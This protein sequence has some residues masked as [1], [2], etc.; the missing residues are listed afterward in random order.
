[1]K[2]NKRDSY[3]VIEATIE[4]KTVNKI[5]NIW[6]TVTMLILL[7]PYVLVWGI[8]ELNGGFLL[9]VIAIYI[10]LIVLHE[11]LHLFGYVFI[12]KAK[13]NEVKLGVFWKHLM[14]YAHCKV[15]LKINHYRIAVMMP[16]ILAIG[17]LIYGY[18][19][20]NGLY[21]TIG[22]L[23]SISSFGDF[24]ILWNLINYQKDAYIQDH[25]SEIGCIV[26]V[27]K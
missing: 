11:L 14:P 22:I 21:F 2:I 26:H 24:I 5:V 6:G 25:S 4:A 1:M 12:G 18:A 16:V 8:G 17:P 7:I 9:S 23:M 13:L 27:P 19:S 10:V 3:K 15:P 20:G